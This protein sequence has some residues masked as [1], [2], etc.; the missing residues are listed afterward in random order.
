MKNKNLQISQDIKI[1]MN[2]DG[3]T[4]HYSKDMKDVKILKELKCDFSLTVDV[5][6]NFDGDAYD[7]FDIRVE[8]LKVFDMNNDYKILDSEG[9]RKLSDNIKEKVQW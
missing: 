3:R 4:G 1:K 9:L 2:W 7:L 8:D 6:E 5:V